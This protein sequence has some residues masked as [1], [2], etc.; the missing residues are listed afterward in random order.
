MIYKLLNPTSSLGFLWSPCIF[1]NVNINKESSICGLW[2]DIHYSTL[3]T[4]IFWGRCGGTLFSLSFN[5][6]WLP[7][8]DFVFHSLT[9]CVVENFP[10]ILS[11][12]LSVPWSVLKTWALTWNQALLE[13]TAKTISLSSNQLWQIRSTLLSA[14]SVPCELKTS[15]KPL[16]TSF[17]PRLCLPSL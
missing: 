14:C 8:S 7:S 17:V 4:Q 9:S 15:I 13:L 11:S 1:K 3:F 16:V 12:I 5:S 10:C 2:Q 6:T